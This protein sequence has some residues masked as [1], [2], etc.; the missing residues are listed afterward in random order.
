MYLECY[1]I[2]QYGV[3]I[4]QHT[5]ELVLRLQESHLKPIDEIIREDEPGPPDSQDS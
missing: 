1:T 3:A 5:E 4:L 2:Y